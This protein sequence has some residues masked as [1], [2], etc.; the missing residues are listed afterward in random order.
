MRTA[1]A[2]RGPNQASCLDLLGNPPGDE[3]DTC[4]K[5]GEMHHLMAHQT[6]VGEPISELLAKAGPACKQPGDTETAEQTRHPEAKFT[7]AATHPELVSG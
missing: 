2:Q 5:Q 4:I 7:A 1:A 6:G 3:G